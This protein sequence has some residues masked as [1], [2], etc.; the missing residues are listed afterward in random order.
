MALITQRVGIPYWWSISAFFNLVILCSPWKS[1]RVCHHAFC[2]PWAFGIAQTTGA[3]QTASCEFSR[4]C[5]VFIWTHFQAEAPLNFSWEQHHHCHL[6]LPLSPPLPS[7]FFSLSS[8]SPS[9]SSSST[10][11][12][13]FFFSFFFNTNFYL[14][15]AR[16][17]GRH[18]TG[19]A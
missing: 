6:P 14:V 4:V 12:T 18:F 15:L 10:A 17:C 2:F 16:S 3:G 7:L 9:S 11:S 1:D 5:K 8:S 19:T 13:S